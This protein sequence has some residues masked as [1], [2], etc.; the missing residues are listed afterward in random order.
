MMLSQT[1][2][3]ILDKHL[4]I[5]KPCAYRRTR[6]KK[7]HIRLHIPRQQREASSIADRTP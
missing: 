2:A 3:P 7:N 4:P 1:K 6:P 5:G